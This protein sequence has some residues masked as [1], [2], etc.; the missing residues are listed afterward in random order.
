[1]IGC[2]LH[3]LNMLLRYAVDRH[4]PGERRRLYQLPT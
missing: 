4:E 1:M 2:D 3:D